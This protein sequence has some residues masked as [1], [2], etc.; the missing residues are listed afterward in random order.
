MT[1]LWH[2]LFNT[3]YFLFLFKGMWHLFDFYLIEIFYGPS[4][5]YTKMRYRL[6]ICKLSQKVLRY[7]CMILTYFGIT[8][9]F[10]FF[11]MF[12]FQFQK[13]STIQ[14]NFNAFYLSSQLFNSIFDFLWKL[15]G[16]KKYRYGRNWISIT[17]P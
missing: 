17:C 9:I 1:L 15:D 8:K 16:P 5:F 7:V 14:T 13:F 4:N 10:F 2:I 3:Q 6:K 12:F 11:G